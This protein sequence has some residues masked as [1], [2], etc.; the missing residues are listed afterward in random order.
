M[1][2]GRLGVSKLKCCRRQTRKDQCTV[3]GE[4]E[5][6]THVILRYVKFYSWEVEIVSEKWRNLREKTV[7]KGSVNCGNGNCL[8]SL[9]DYLFKVHT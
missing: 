5:H 8:K 9:S 7:L 6:T 3:Y 1:A 4:V 2:L